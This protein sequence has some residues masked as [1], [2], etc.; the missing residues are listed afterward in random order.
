MAGET[1]VKQ[2]PAALVRDLSGVALAIVLEQRRHSRENCFG[3]AEF[4]YR[5]PGQSEKHQVQDRLTGYPCL[6]QSVVLVSAKDVDVVDDLH[7]EKRSL[8][9]RCAGCSACLCCHH[10]R[11]GW[12]VASALLASTTK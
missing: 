5:Q 3:N 8:S 1:S 7:G 9:D 10:S 6:F 2:S 11:S 4:W 12:V